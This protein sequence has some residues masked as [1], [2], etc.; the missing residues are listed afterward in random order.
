MIRNQQY[1]GSFIDQDTPCSA[2]ALYKHAAALQITKI[3]TPVIEFLSHC[4]DDFLNQKI[5]IL[6]AACK[7]THNPVNS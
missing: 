2:L 3:Q 1:L 6:G 5:N 4:H 7:T